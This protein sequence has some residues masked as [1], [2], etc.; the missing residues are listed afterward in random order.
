M[1]F[2]LYIKLPEYQVHQVQKVVESPLNRVS[3]DQFPSLEKTYFISFSCIFPEP[4]C[5]YTSSL[6]DGRQVRLV[7]F[8]FTVYFGDCFISVKKFLILFLLLHSI[9]FN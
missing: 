5:E 2:I 6:F 1:Y 4:F 7:C 8:Y 9:P 3:S